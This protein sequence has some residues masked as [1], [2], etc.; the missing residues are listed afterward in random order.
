[1]YMHTQS[2]GGMY[3]PGARL[4]VGGAVLRHRAAVE[5]GEDGGRLKPVCVHHLSMWHTHAYTYIYR[6]S[7]DERFAV[8]R[9]AGDLEEGNAA[10]SG[11]EGWRRS[12]FTLVNGQYRPVLRVAPGEW[13]RWRLIYAGQ[14]RARVS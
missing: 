11:G 2:R 3:S 12:S 14:V 6:M 8:G 7:G 1:M 13:T 4:G 10:G 9:G 5:R